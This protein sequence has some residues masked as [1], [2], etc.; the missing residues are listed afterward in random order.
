MSEPCPVCKFPVTIYGCS[1][2]CLQATPE[3]VEA[4]KAMKPGDFGIYPCPG[5]GDPI[6]DTYEQ[7]ERAVCHECFTKKRAEARKTLLRETVR[8]LGA[9]AGLQDA[10]IDL[11][12]QIKEELAWD[13]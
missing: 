13:K 9:R 3:E 11:L 1:E 10:E 8:I 7:G 6:E 5:C 12:R 4:F 2:F